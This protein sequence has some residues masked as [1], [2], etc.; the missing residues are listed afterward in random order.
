MNAIIYVRVSTAEQAEFGYSLKTQEE[1]CVNFA[2]SQ[3]Y[4]V[5]K[6]FVEKGESAKTLNRTALKELLEYARTN[7]NIIDA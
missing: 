2:K 7:K 5:L 1:M 4:N 6:V 3:K